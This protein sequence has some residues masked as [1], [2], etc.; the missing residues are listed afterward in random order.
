MK[1]KKTNILENLL[2]EISPTEQ[3]KI[4]AKMIIAAQ[5]ADGIKAKKWKNK[6]L[7]NALGRDTPSI[8]TKWLSGTHNFTIDTLIELE[9]ALDI[10]LLNKKKNIITRKYFTFSKNEVVDPFNIHQ[11][12]AFENE[13]YKL[14]FN[15]IEA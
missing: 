15:Q 6:D 4:D 11:N 7:L 12:R 13:P 10:S 5:I 14:K 3:A 8:V 1:K 2:N 9:Q